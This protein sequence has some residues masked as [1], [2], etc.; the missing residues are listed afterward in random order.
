MNKFLLVA[1]A[2]ILLLGC[3]KKNNPA[4]ITITGKWIAK[5]D[6]IREYQDGVLTETDYVK[7]NGT[8]YIQ[9]NKDQTGTTTVNGVVSSF[10]YTTSGNTMTINIPQTLAGVAQPPL[11]ETVKINILTANSLLLASS[12]NVDLGTGVMY[13][14]TE[15]ESYER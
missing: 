15:N 1:I 2:A 14:E 12:V 11:V 7:A 3:S 6:T 9:F 4:P 13:T 8:D 10:T 5:A